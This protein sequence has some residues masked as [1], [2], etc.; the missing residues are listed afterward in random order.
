MKRLCPLLVG[1]LCFVLL[2]ILPNKISAQS[3]VNIVPTFDRSNA[4]YNY[5]DTVVITFSNIPFA[6]TTNA[7]L[8]YH[9]GIGTDANKTLTAPAAALT[10]VTSNPP[11]DTFLIPD[12]KNHVQ[13]TGP[14]SYVLN[15]PAGVVTKQNKFTL[16]LSLDTTQLVDPNTTSPT[17]FNLGYSVAASK[18]LDV[19]HFTVNPK[20]T[21]KVSFNIVKIN[22]NTHT[23]WQKQGDTPSVDA[24]SPIYI[25]IKP[26]DL[27]HTYSY[28]I[29]KATSGNSSGKCQKD[30]NEKD[31]SVCFVKWTIPSN[32]GSGQKIID[33]NDATTKQGPA[34]AEYVIVKGK[35]PAPTGGIQVTAA[36]DT[37][38]K[39]KNVKN[40]CDYQLHEI[41]DASPCTSGDSSEWEC[42]GSSY[43]CL[44]N[45]IG[46]TGSKLIQCQSYDQKPTPTPPLAMCKELISDKTDKHCQAIATPIGDLSTDP[47]EFIPTLFRI[48]LSL[49]GGIALLLVIYSGYQLMTS[50]GN[51]EVVKA[52][53][54]RLTSAFVGL[55]FLIFSL[56][57]LQV[58]GVDILNL[59][60]FGR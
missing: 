6:T 14:L 45:E 49:S 41:T 33:V 10:L 27:T 31:P 5:G 20:T 44:G 34:S 56:V 57:I 37:C 19:G 59:P 12:D 35:T 25:Y 54:E 29:D 8:T 28:G 2:L 11:P 40:Y 48:L 51:P 55:L 46:D 38:T 1:F 47:K 9:F 17:A 60:G 24:G 18:N 43:L 30:P 50:Q 42:N 52:A 53:R 58:I 15:P 36:P 16:T 22:D 4:T 39:A 32:T 3:T 7:D 26:G 23:I 13:V 21:A